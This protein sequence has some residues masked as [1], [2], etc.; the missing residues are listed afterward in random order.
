MRQ[1]LLNQVL[2]K[3]LLISF[4]AKLKQQATF[5]PFLKFQTKHSPVSLLSPETA[6]L[7]QDFAAEDLQLAE[8]GMADYIMGLDQED[9]L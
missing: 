8:M 5:I 6:R 1:P 9:S 4:I 3:N 2:V 7:Y